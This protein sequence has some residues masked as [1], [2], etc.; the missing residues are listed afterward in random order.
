M[1]F[2][3][4]NK[5]AI[6]LT[7]ALLK[8]SRDHQHSDFWIQQLEETLK[9]VIEEDIESLRMKYALISRAGMGSYLDWYPATISENEDDEYVETLWWSLYGQWRESLKWLE[10]QKNT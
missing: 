5:G 3:H 9:A 6:R 1:S 7:S 2:P 10:E 8:F 4:S